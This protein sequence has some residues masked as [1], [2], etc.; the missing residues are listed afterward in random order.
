MKKNDNRVYL[1]P[2]GAFWIHLLQNIFVLDYIN[3]VWEVMKKEA[4]PKKID[5]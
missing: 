5:I 4:F 1:T 3:N 2:N